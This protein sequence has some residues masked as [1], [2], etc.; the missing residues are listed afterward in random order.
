MIASK[1][2]HGLPCF[3]EIAKQK[4]RDSK[5]KME[6]ELEEQRQYEEAIRQEELEEKR[7]AKLVLG[8][9]ITSTG[10]LENFLRCLSWKI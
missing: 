9:T 10:Y 7:K 3:S 1:V 6:L 8:L 2:L 4:I 5:A